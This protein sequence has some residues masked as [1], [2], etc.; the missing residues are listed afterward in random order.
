MPYRTRDTEL[1][2]HLITLRVLSSALLAQCQA[3][4]QEAGR[5]W[6]DLVER[7]AQARLAG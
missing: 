5:L 4:R 7:H 2:V 3:L 1:R 6:T